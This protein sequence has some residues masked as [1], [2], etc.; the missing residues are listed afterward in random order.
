MSPSAST[1]FTPIIRTQLDWE[2]RL[3]EIEVGEYSASQ[4]IGEIT[5]FTRSVV[6]IIK[7]TKVDIALQ[8]GPPSSDIVGTCPL[9]GGAV[10]ETKKSFR[11]VNWKTRGCKF[12][13]WKQISGHKMTKAQ[14]KELLAK[15]KTKPLK[16]KGKTGKVFEAHLILKSDGKV[17]TFVTIDA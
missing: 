12:G 2:H 16:F 11:C 15:K 10:I 5:E 9:C 13:V 14:V 7:Q 8:T 6:R 4:F 1:E 3:A 17:E